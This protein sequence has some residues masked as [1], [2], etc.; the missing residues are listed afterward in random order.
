MNAGTTAV[1]S[2][3]FAAKLPPM[4]SAEN[5]YGKLKATKTKGALL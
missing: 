4:N 3:I 2:E 1:I 5:G